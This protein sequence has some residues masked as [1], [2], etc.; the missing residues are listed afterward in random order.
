M[1]TIS[2]LIAFEEEI[3]L[4]FNSG[5]I[6]H[7]VHLESGNEEHL[8]RMFHDIR[9]EDWVVGSWRSHLKAL[10]K[11][12]PPDELKSAIR[13]G[14]SISLC[15]PEYRVLSSAIV[16]GSVSIAVGIALSIKRLGGKERVHCWI[17]DMTAETGIAHESMKY[18]KGHEL[19]IKFIIEDNGHSVLT[20]TK[21][22]WGIGEDSDIVRYEYRSKWP[23]CGA[24]SRVQF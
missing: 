2:D 7:P 14:S 16:G 18:A 9:H 19:P 15:F 24:G 17:G 8:I 6:R 11:G 12:V 20:P 23:H 1:L 21:E 10:L 3:A 4:E 5:K 22:A 13:S